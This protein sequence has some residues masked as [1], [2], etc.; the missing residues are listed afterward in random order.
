ML[1]P[2]KFK[3][4]YKEK[5]WG[6]KRLKSLFNKD[7]SPLANCGESWELSGVSGNLSVI[8][9]GFLAGNNISELIEIYM[10]ELVGERVFEK[11]GQEFPLLIKL[12]D[13]ESYLS[14][15]VHPDDN[16]AMKHHNSFGKTEMWVVLDAQPGAEIIAGFSKN[17]DKETYVEHLN[18]GT[19]KE[20]LNVEQAR[21]GD[22]FY[23]PA[24]RI[25]AI[26]AGV[27]LLEIQQ[28]SDVTYRVYDWDRR[29]ENGNYR[30]LHTGQ[31]VEVLDFN[32]Q[33]Q[34]KTP[35]ALEENQFCELVKSPYFTTRMMAFNKEREID[36]SFLDSFVIY[37]CIEGNCMINYSGGVEV[38]QAGNVALIPAELKNIRLTP[39]GKCTIVET[40]IG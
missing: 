8:E 20:I 15:Q 17:V 29:D 30:E 35:Y 11:Y 33:D 5:I 22:V 23:I 38:L 21:P 24:G 14:I 16:Y 19:L 18:N 4:I 26:G 34:Y 10:G 39:Q 9:N 7:F 12:L 37:S 27:T 3:P 1:Y 32:K 36:Y 13:T 40:Y 28:T 2:L 31:A 6:G 25:H